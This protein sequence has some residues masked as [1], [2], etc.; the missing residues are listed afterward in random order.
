MGKCSK[1]V[2]YMEVND[3]PVFNEA[4]LKEL[5]FQK[6]EMIKGFV[7]AKIDEVFFHRL[8]LL[9]NKTAESEKGLVEATNKI[10]RLEQ[11]IEVCDKLI[12]EYS[13]KK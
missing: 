4:V 2:W 12:Q 8:T 5:Y 9:G 1:G 6:Y 11:A 10:K 7:R 13:P 3:Y